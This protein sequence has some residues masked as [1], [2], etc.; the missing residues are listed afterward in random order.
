MKFSERLKDPEH[1]SVA[2]IGMGYVGLP[3][4]LEFVEG[5]CRVTGIDV[6]P[7]KPRM[8][9]EGR[10]YLKHIPSERIADA[11]K[12]GRLECTT[13]FSDV[14]DSDAIIICVPT[15]LGKSREP[16]LSY[17]TSTGRQ[18]SEFLQPGQL[19]VL[20]STTY[21]GTT[22][23]QLVPILEESGLKAGSDF[24]VA[25]SPE[26]ED[27]GN[28]HYTTRTI[29]KLVGAMTAEGVEA[30]E[31][32]YSCAVENVV[33]VSSPEV[34]EMAKITE[35]TYRAVN[36]ALVNELKMLAT[37]MGV[38]IWEVIRA[39]STKPFGYTPFYPGPGLGGHCIPIDPFYL[40]W[41]AH[42]FGMPTRF[43]EL[44]GEI[45]TGMPSFVVSIITRALNDRKKSVRGSRV[46]ILGMAYKPDIDDI[47]E[48]PALQVM[49][50]LLELGAE[51]DYNDPYVGSIGET[52]QTSRRPVS[53]ELTESSLSGYDCTVIITDHSC[54]D[55][56]WIVDNSSLIIDTRNACSN[57]T[58]GTEKVV[59]A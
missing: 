3:L 23:E 14:K 28:K 41:K 49:D 33:T 54:Y 38:D 50:Q 15:P 31:K 2:I 58:G 4:A 36:I 12:T 57:V 21:P 24:F 10:S 45:N 44:A 18:V 16:D 27:P 5:G 19:V 34:A 9:A 32:V 13:N 55:Y 11:V 46:L 8:I 35:N 20:E 48:T 51:V 40:T 59:K 6:D 1:P 42:Q 25:F 17:V 30:A 26:R 7:E 53:V 56:Q 37:R 47:R 22:R 43:I 52:R 29:P 39:A